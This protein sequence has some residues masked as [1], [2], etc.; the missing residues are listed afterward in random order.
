M[1]NYHIYEEMGRGKFS[2]VYKGRKKKTIE[3]VAIKSVERS[4][5]QKLMNEVRIFHNLQHK[6]VLRFHNWYETRNHLWIVF[7]FCPGGDLFKLIEEDKKLPEKTVKKFAFELIEGLSYLHENGVIYADLKPSNILINEFSNLKF[8][9]FGLSKKIADLTA[10][11]S[12]LPE[13]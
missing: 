11:A 9:D 3:Y 7:E 13:E 2:V 8:G 1:N 12:V 5:R 4:R 10:K 6:N